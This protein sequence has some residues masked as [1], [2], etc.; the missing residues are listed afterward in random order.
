VHEVSAQLVRSFAE[1]LQKQLEAAPEEAGAAVSA[2]TRPV[3][4]LSLGARAVGAS[5]GRLVQRVL[6]RPR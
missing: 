2:Q 3:G 5:F 6:R 1:C 4:G